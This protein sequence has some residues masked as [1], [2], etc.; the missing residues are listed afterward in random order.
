MYTSNLIPHKADRVVVA[1]EVPAMTRTVSKQFRSLPFSGR[2]L[3]QDA[4]EG[5]FMERET[6]LLNI[7][8]RVATARIDVVVDRPLQRSLRL[9][10][11]FDGIA[12]CALAT[13]VRRDVVGFPQDFLA[14][15]LDRDGQS[16]EAHDR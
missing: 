11:V 6:P 2:V 15:V 14:R 9:Q 16:A 12:N 1:N 5:F 10:N 7:G 13:F 4:S 8:A 3:G